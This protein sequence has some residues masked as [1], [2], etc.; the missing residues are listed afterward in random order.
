MV[1][2]MIQRQP[3]NVT[4]ENNYDYMGFAFARV[5]LVFYGQRH[6]FDY[7]WQNGELGCP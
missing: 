2:S 5:S 1:Y 7:L 6:W 4:K 3:T